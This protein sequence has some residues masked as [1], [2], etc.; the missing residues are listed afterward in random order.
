MQFDRFVALALIDPHHMIEKKKTDGS[1]A[2]QTNKLM[3]ESSPWKLVKTDSIT[4]AQQILLDE[5]IYVCVESLRICGIL[6][7]PFM[8]SKSKH[9]LDLLGVDPN[10][11]MFSHT[12]AR[13]DL[14]YGTPAVDIGR[15]TDS[16]LFPPLR[17]DF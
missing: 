10:E 4:P 3:Q 15:G 17:S 12:M 2:T 13:S 6:L 9:L 1:R 16:V 8:Q 14:N 5:I 11:R 7:Q